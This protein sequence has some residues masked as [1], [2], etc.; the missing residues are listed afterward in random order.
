MVI[1][2]DEANGRAAADQYGA[3]WAPRLD[4]LAD[5]DAAVVAAPTEHHKDLALR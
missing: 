4:A 5:V 3:L 2:P 1:D